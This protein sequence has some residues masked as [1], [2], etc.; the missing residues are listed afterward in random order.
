MAELLVLLL[1][2]GVTEDEVERTKQRMIDSAVFARDGLRQA[3][4][5]FGTALASGQSVA[6]VEGWPERIRE[7]SVDDVNAAARA[8]LRPETSTTGVLLPEAEG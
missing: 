7:V 4:R 1:E 5:V 6:D 2:D 3:A 8:V